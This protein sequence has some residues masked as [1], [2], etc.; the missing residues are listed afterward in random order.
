M[1]ITQFAVPAVVKAVSVSAT[2]ERAFAYFVFD[3]AR[4][5]PLAQFHTGRDPVDCTIEP[6]VG[7]RVFERAADGRETLWGSVVAYDPPRHLA[8]SWIV[9]ELTP[10]QAQQ[11]DLRFTPEGSGRG[12]R[13][14]VAGKLWALAFAGATEDGS[15]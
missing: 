10:D 7:G 5:W 3:M 4:W 8:F 11:I 2:P 13:R 15:T 6:R 1:T 9:G 14:A 12:G